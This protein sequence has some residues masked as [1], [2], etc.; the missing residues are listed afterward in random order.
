MQAYDRNMDKNQDKY[1]QGDKAFYHVAGEVFSAIVLKNECSDSHISYRLKLCNP[2]KLNRRRAI[3]VGGLEISCIKQRS[4]IG[5]S[6]Y[7][8]DFINEKFV[9]NE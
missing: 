1:H 9:Q 4:A 5:A 6:W 3:P 2:I 8:L 7:L